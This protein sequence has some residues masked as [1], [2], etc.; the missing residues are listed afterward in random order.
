MQIC[1]PVDKLIAAHIAVHRK[2]PTALKLPERLFA[3]NCDLR[4]LDEYIA[5]VQDAFA[6]LPAPS[7]GPPIVYTPMHG[8]GGSIVARLLPALI[9][10]TPQVS[11]ATDPSAF[12]RFLILNFARPGFPT[13]KKAA[14]L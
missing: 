10:C 9:F 3:P 4:A 8:V 7:N 2:C 1:S 6:A 12:R 5:D 13:R 14:R 11:P